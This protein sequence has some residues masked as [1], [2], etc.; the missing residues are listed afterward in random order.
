MNDAHDAETDQAT[1]YMRLPWPLVAAGLIG[2]LAVVLGIGLYANRYLRPQVG[3]VL[4][5]EPAAI[6]AAAPLTPTPP[7]APAVP[8]P[9][10][11]L[12]VQAP[13]SATDTPRPALAAPIS[14][15]SAPVGVTPSALP[16]V[17]PALADEVGRAYVMFWRVRSQALL[18]LDPSHL[19]EVMDGDYLQNFV[20]RLNE[21]RVEGRA[22]KTQI[23]LNYTVVQATDRAATVID[24]LEDSSFYVLPGTEQPLADQANDVLLIQFKFLRADGAWK[25]VD[26]VRQE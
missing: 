15:P 9:A 21:L 17:E 24:R 5:P 20:V 7:A 1:P 13:T 10:P 18:E 2:I 14:T 19:S 11:T 22:I 6:A 8:T 3:L 4:T 12:V 23:T 26:S 25:V 16:T